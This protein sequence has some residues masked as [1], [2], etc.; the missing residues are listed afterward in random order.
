[1]STATC[2]PVAPNGAEHLA[3]LAEVARIA[4]ADLAL[5]PLLQR[6]TDTLADRFGWD[7]VSLVRVDRDQGW[8]VCEALTTDLPSEI[9]VGYRRELGS[10][11]VGH[12][13]A[14]GEP[15]VID[16]ASNHPDFVETL[17]GVQSEICVPIKH[18][19]EMVGLLNVESLRL[20]EFRGQLPLLEAIAD[21]IA[22]AIANARLYE[23]LRLR[24]TAFEVLNHVT[25]LATR[26]GDIQACLD[27]IARYVRERFDLSVA[28]VV[29]SDER[30]REWEHRA[31][32]TRDPAAVIPRSYW[33]IAAGVAGRAIR[34][35]EP[36]LVL[37]V[38]ADPDYFGVHGDVAAELVVP[39]RFREEILGAILYEADDATLLR[40]DTVKLFETLA[41]QIAG[42]I[43][44]LVVNRRLADSQR[45]LAA[46]ADRLASVNG[47]L[48][49]LTLTD[50]LTGVA[51]RRCFEDRLTEEWR[52]AQRMGIPVTLALLDVDHFKAYNDHFGH[53]A[54][55]DCLR[56][57]AQILARGLGRAGELVARW[58]G[59]EFAAILPGSEAA[60]AE[61][62]LE[63]VRRRLEA[64]KIPHPTSPTAPWVTLSA[65]AATD[66]PELRRS[67][68]T[69]LERADQALYRAKRNGRNRTE[70][71]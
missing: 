42:A 61:R 70:V 31:I 41:D 51:N 39:L 30:Q 19:G 62:N 2:T 14:S 44:L 52:R 25:R 24:V 20:A 1:M 12:V 16:D 71:G 69:L 4:T 21:Q 27:G 48:L 11:I 56:Q 23:E 66:V 34:T 53:P 17:A 46:T 5:R 45:Q 49:R 63:R 22:G 59:E 40:P 10:G 65:G 43:E 18:R 9:H 47:E 13:A 64:A 58:G 33:P 60:V 54:G 36:Q 6:I 50:G 7:L 68:E 35:G 57:V 55:D 3:I 67:P 15:L 38:T 8:F 29:V 26:P 32:A 28:A 37:D